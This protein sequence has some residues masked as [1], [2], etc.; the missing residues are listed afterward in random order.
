MNPVTK[1]K[2]TLQKQQKSKT[3]AVKEPKEKGVQTVMR[4]YGFAEREPIETVR[5]T[6]NEL[7]LTSSIHIVHRADELSTIAKRIYGDSNAYLV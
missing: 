3:G 5:G 7:Q 1:K 4:G 6:H 2:V